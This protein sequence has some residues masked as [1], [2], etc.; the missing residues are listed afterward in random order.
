MREKVKPKTQVRSKTEPGAPSASVQIVSERSLL[1]R[2]ARLD[3]TVFPLS[4][5]FLAMSDAKD[6][7]DQAVVFDLVDGSLVKTVRSPL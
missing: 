3:T 1:I 7:H 5:D 4:I 2:A 6:Q